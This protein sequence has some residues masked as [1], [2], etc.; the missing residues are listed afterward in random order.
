MGYASA[1]QGRAESG[2]SLRGRPL[3]PAIF[4]QECYDE[5]QDDATL[6]LRSCLAN[7]PWTLQQFTGQ[8]RR[9]VFQCVSCGQQA[10]TGAH[11]DEQIFTSLQIQAHHPN[12]GEAVSA[13]YTEELDD[14]F[15]GNCTNAACGQRWSHKCQ[16]VQESPRV[17]FLEIKRWENTAAGQPHRLPSNMT[18]SENLTVEGNTYYISSGGISSTHVHASACLFTKTPN[19][20]P[21]RSNKSLFQ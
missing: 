11:S 20:L 2:A 6:F 19:I 3:Y 4:L 8:Y 7:C 18:I 9:A 17:L 5:H 21:T 13:S 1:M 16:P 15:R 12:V 10:S 14:D